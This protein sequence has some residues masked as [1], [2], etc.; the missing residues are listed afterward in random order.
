MDQP[1][2]FTGVPDADLAILARLPDWQVAAMCQVDKYL[3]SLCTPAFWQARYREHFPRRYPLLAGQSRNWRATYMATALYQQAYV[4]RSLTQDIVCDSWEKAYWYFLQRVL[5][6]AS[7][8]DSGLPAAFGMPPEIADFPALGTWLRQLVNLTPTTLSIINL[9]REPSPTA[10]F[11]LADES[12]PRQR[13]VAN[14]ANEVVELPDGKTFGYFSGV[15]QLPQYFVIAPLLIRSRSV[16][17]EMLPDGLIDGRAEEIFRRVR[18]M[19]RNIRAVPLN[20]P[21]APARGGQVSSPATGSIPYAG[22]PRYLDKLLGSNLPA[23]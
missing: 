20:L 17:F 3:A 19:D 4:V 22:P 23:E 1:S 2:T 13:W 12:H 15:S 11:Y 16:Y 21:Q 6:V 10:I 18:R 5:S 9:N 8:L 7:Y 14:V